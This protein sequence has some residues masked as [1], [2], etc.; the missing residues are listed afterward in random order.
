MGVAPSAN[1][2]AKR[3]LP[4]LFKLTTAAESAGE[5]CYIGAWIATGD[6][7]HLRDPQPLENI[8]TRG[9]GG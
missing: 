5:P 4:R 7:G 6:S 2:V 3:V 1:N 9:M 8:F